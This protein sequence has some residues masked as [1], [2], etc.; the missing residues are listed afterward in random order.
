MPFSDCFASRMTR[1]SFAA[2]SAATASAAASSSAAGT[3]RSTVPNSCSCRAVTVWQVYTIARSSG[4]GT[5][6][7]RWVAAPSAP[8]STS[9][10]PNVASSAATMTSAL[11]AR[12]I[13]PPRQKP[14]TAAITGTGHS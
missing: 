13:P 12:P 7:E 4:C 3:T 9:G 11:P 5:S 2:I 1:G 8:R 10:R 6:R 14:C